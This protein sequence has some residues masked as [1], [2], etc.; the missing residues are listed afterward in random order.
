MAFALSGST[1]TQTGTDTSLSGLSAIAGV[2][3]IANGDGSLYSFPT[4]VLNISGILTIADPSKQTYV[5]SAVRVLSG[6]NYT[7]GTFCTDGITAKTGG[8]HFNSVGVSAQFPRSANNGSFEVQSGGQYKFIGGIYY[9][10]GG[11]AYL[12]GATNIE[13]F[14]VSV[15]ASRAFG[16]GSSRIFYGTPNISKTNCKHY[17]LG[18]DLFQKPTS[19]RPFSVKAFNSEY[20]SQYVGSNNGGTDLLF[21]ASGLSNQDGTFDFDNYDGGYVELYNCASAANLKVTCQGGRPYHCVPLFQNVNIKITNLSNVV[22]NG[23]NYKFID[24]PVSNSPTTIIT[25]NGG[26]KSWDFINPITYTGTT[27]TSGLSTTTPVLQVWH[28]AT[29]LKNLRFPLFTINPQFRAYALETQVSSLI[30][31]SDT[32]QSLSI[33][34]TA[35]PLSI[36]QAQAQALTGISFSPSG[37]NAGT[38]TVTSNKTVTELWASYRNYISQIANFDS[39]D[40]WIF[41]NAILNT[42]NWSISNSAIITGNITTTG[43]VT[44]T[45][46]V[47]GIYTDSTG[48]SGQLSF[49]AP[50]NSQVL[51]TSNVGATT[52]IASASGQTT[53]NIPPGQTGTYTVKV[54]QY[55]LQEKILTQIITGGGL[56]A[57]GT[58]TLIPNTKFVDI[59]ANVTVYTALETSQKIYDWTQYYATTAVGITQNFLADIISSKL[60]FGANKIANTTL[61]YTGTTIG[62]NS[63]TVTGINITTTGTLLANVSPIYPQQITDSTGTT[64]WLKV[65]LTTG[66]VYQDNFD[67]TF[68]TASFTTLLPS[69]A[70]SNIIYTLTA[71]G[72]KKLFNQTLTYSTNLLPTISAT[73]VQDTNVI[74]TTTDFL[75]VATSLDTSQKIYDTLSQYQATSIGITKDISSIVKSFQAIDFSTINFTQSA[76]ATNTIVFASNT[77]TV[78]SSNLA[79]DSYFSTGNFTQIGSPTLS[80][81]VRIRMFNLDSELVLQ[82]INP[83][84]IYPTSNDRDSNTNISLVITTAVYRYKYGTIV[85]GATLANTLFTKPSSSGTTVDKDYTISLGNSIISLDQIAILTVINANTQGQKIRDAMML[86][87]TVGNKSIDDKII[88]ASLLI[89]TN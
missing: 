86:T 40:T 30:L 87:S 35:I 52:Y 69:T 14:E 67:N 49:T 33:A 78:K 4:L 16:V 85:S 15:I 83:L 81:S 89:P 6:G 2:T 45:G 70:T 22:Q 17:D 25:T 41:E 88:D 71:R 26:I 64:N 79:S 7:S 61:G 60:D 54:R 24:A 62:T 57:L 53:V 59:L 66:Q 34:M 37:A 9:V 48:T 44:G 65:N 77:L 21:T 39:N 80:D 51:I 63:A 73:L 20:V 1:I 11:I 56:F 13:E 36:T 8:I 55:G 42:G 10:S 19:T 68:K 23:V 18:I 29:S 27:N 74:D 31:G 5:A 3:T 38:I 32:A 50:T 72:S 43:T 58:I 12:S 82:S 28:G 46:T 84:K 76:T 75:T 47:N